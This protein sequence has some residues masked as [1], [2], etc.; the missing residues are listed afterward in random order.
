[1]KKL[2]IY[3]TFFLTQDTLR[4]YEGSGLTDSWNDKD[5]GIPVLNRLDRWVKER[6]DYDHRIRRNLNLMCHRN[7][8]GQDDFLHVVNRSD[9][10]TSFNGDE[11][12]M[13]KIDKKYIYTHFYSLIQIQN[14]IFIIYYKFLPVYFD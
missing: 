7:N 3:E 2:I 9:R 14:L 5:I 4:I 13:N 12:E 8:S 11:N 6:L 1:M 10:F